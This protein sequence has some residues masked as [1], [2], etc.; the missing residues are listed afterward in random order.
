MLSTNAFHSTSLFLFF[1]FYHVLLNNTAPF[2]HSSSVRSNEGLIN[3]RNFSSR[4]PLWWPFLLYSSPLPPTYHHS[5]FQPLP[6]ISL[7]LWAHLAGSVSLREMSLGWPI[8]QFSLSDLWPWGSSVF[9]RQGLVTVPT[10]SSLSF[11]SH[12][13]TNVKTTETAS[14][15]R[16][17]VIMAASTDV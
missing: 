1:T 3:A 10:S 12:T 9:Q 15:L 16:S 7:C 6:P 14:L 5:F 11:A 2:I 4:N 8:C 17:V 13:S